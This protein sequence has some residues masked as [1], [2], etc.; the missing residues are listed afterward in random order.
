[1]IHHAN[2]LKNKTGHNYLLLATLPLF[3][4]GVFLLSGCDHAST[5]LTVKTAPAVVDNP[6]KE[7][8]LTTITLTS[9]AEKR[10]GLK[11]TTTQNQSIGRTLTQ[12]GEIVAVPGLTV[13]VTAPV[14]GK[15]HGSK[16]VSG[17]RVSKGQTVFTL[18]ALPNDTSGLGADEEVAVRQKQLA[19]VQAKVDRFTELNKDKTTSDRLLQEAQAE[20]KNAQAAL[21]ASQA[22]QHFLTDK[23]TAADKP[24]LSVI[25]IEA[26][27]SGVIQTVSATPSQL[28]SGGAPL[29]NVT[30]LGTVWVRV[31]VYAGDLSSVSGVQTARIQPLGE[32]IDAG[33]RMAKAVAA[34]PTANPQAISTDLF[35]AMSNT[36]SAFQVGQKVSVTLSRGGSQSGLTIP[37]SAVVYD[38]EGGTWVYE[39]TQPH[40]YTRRRV[41]VSRVVEGSAVLVKPLPTNAK[42]VY[43]GAAEL[44]GTE[45]GA[46]K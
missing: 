31:P 34:P 27:L 18:M 12:H 6:V 25:D 37:A 13:S 41:L 11:T 38:I 36:D 5:K 26:P 19:V 45:F 14:T 9:Q 15:L 29:F 28:V 22:R 44:F 16:L 43:V 33:V 4:I 40:T 24:H 42:I 10:L 35:F 2:T 23:L 21:E 32:N 17:R 1:M 30:S 20:L 7:S 3:V 46:G 39:L 8:Q